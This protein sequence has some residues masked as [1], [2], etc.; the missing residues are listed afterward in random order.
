MEW[1]GGLLQGE[2]DPGGPHHAPLAPPVGWDPDPGAGAI[3]VAAEVFARNSGVSR[4]AVEEALDIGLLSR[5]RETGARGRVQCLIRVPHADETLGRIIG[6]LLANW[7][8]LANISD[9]MWFARSMRLGRFRLSDYPDAWIDDF[10]ALPNDYARAEDMFEMK[11]LV[12]GLHRD[13]MDFS[14][15]VTARRDGFLR[16]AHV[17]PL[18]G[19]VRKA[20]KAGLGAD[21]PDLAGTCLE[22]TVGKALTA[23]TPQLAARLLAMEPGVARDVAIADC[24]D[25]VANCGLEDE[26]SIALAH[27]RMAIVLKGVARGDLREFRRRVKA[28]LAGRIMRRLGPYARE[29]D[30]INYMACSRRM[31]VWAGEEIPERLRTWLMENRPIVPRDRGFYAMIDRHHERTERKGLKRRKARSDPIAASFDDTLAECEANYAAIVEFDGE[32]AKGHAAA[33]DDPDFAFSYPTAIPGP[34]GRDTGRVMLVNL[35]SVTVEHLMELVRGRFDK[36]V[37][38]RKNFCADYAP[39]GRLHDEG[40]TSQ[41][42][43][44]FESVDAQDGGPTPRPPVWLE[45]YVYGAML[46]PRMLSAPQIEKRRAYMAAS[47]L[48]V[49]YQPQRGVFRFSD[50]LMGKLAGWA[51]AVKGAVVIPVEDVLA[52][53]AIGRVLYRCMAL[54]L[55]RFGALRQMIDGEEGWGFGVLPDG[56]RARAIKVIP[57]LPHAKKNLPLAEKQI[58]VPFEKD[59]LA[60]I[61]ELIDVLIDL[62]GGDP[63]KPKRL[64]VARR[65]HDFPIECKDDRYI[66][67]TGGEVLIATTAAY[68]LSVLLG[69]RVV[70]HDLRHAGSARRYED[71]ES[72]EDV[73][74]VA[75]HSRTPRTRK[76]VQ[77]ADGR[78][79]GG[80]RRA[81]AARD[82]LAEVGKGGDVP[83]PRQP[84]RIAR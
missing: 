50:T 43:I 79:I 73:R 76:Y 51:F 24:C 72:L 54:T 53:G 68:A 74:K 31:E 44:L 39:G 42:V 75:G 4:R 62:D 45:P 10:L 34:F 81:L 35:R 40:F 59:T 82:R 22:R 11:P 58:L 71:G 52:G 77:R 65:A 27:F 78:L 67:Q 14:R 41:R 8:K 20:L 7:V 36:S 32:C 21:V 18:R 28:Y 56:R 9:M 66:L 37:F 13:L 64:R 48:V 49:P 47:G 30:V 83:K 25:A 61:R 46:G 33:G 1:Q 69:R 15:R 38:R 60:A 17:A 23:P 16:M 29:H 19:D 84:R 63:E 2:R 55:T 80:G 70:S 3:E 26:S 5:R 6:R 57:K 12:Y